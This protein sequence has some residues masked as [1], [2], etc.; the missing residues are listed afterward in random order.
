MPLRYLT[1]GESH[2]PALTAILEG[3]PAGM[4]LEPE[5]INTD[6]ARRQHGYGAGPRM[7]LETDQVQILGGVMEG[8]TTG[9]PLALV[10]E[11]RDHARW[12]GKA[13]APFTIPRPGHADLAGAV[14]Y[15]YDDLRPALERASARETAVRVAVGAV[16]RSL[17][18]HF[19]VQV[20]GYVA[21]I[22]PVSA[23]LD[24]L[25]LEE[26]IA[27]AAA[28]DVHCPD[29]QAAD[30]MQAAIRQVMTDRDTLGGIIEVVAL[31][32]PAG[33]GSF[34]HWDRKLDGRLGAAVLSIPAIKGVEFGPA[35][36]NTRRPGTQV[37]DPVQ[38]EDGQIG[39]AHV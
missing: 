23:A 38:L 16:C 3:I 14:K 36:E 39:R 25:S 18:A 35:F 24:E 7:K 15:A 9:G 22:G 34:V 8:H 2:G 32:L 17:L 5:M 20:G 1:A 30:A 12:R 10:V 28:N 33:L 21:A 26:R 29:P 27:R 13:V 6:L 31:G 4:P 19:G 11:N 37:H